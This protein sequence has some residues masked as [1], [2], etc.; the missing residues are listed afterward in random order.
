MVQHLHVGNLISVDL[1]HYSPFDIGLSV[2]QLLQPFGALR[3]LILKRCRELRS[4]PEPDA[5]EWRLLTS[6]RVHHRLAKLTNEGDKVPSLP[7]L[8]CLSLPQTLL[9]LNLANIRML[10]KSVGDRHKLLCVLFDG[11]RLETRLPPA[12]LGFHVAVKLFNICLR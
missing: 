9:T 10:D 11:P 3:H 12:V 8:F 5:P 2:L 1:I 7:R 6:T 4:I